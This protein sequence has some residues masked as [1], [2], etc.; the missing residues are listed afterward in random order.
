M[1]DSIIRSLPCHLL[2]LNWPVHFTLH[3]HYNDGHK[4]NRDISYWL[5][6]TSA[7]SGDPISLFCGIL[8]LLCWGGQTFGYGCMWR[9]MYPPPHPITLYREYHLIY[10]DPSSFTFYQLRNYGWLWR[11]RW[12][13]TVPNLFPCP[14][15]K[16]FLEIVWC[17]CG[18]AETNYNS[19]IPGLSL[20]TP[21]QHQ[22]H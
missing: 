16:L 6:G 8:A 1:E 21:L 4:K 7:A 12:V 17:Q 3:S 14:G 18:V 11:W 10:F 20:W 5:D 2:N 13:E 9:L 15:R 19:V 22:P